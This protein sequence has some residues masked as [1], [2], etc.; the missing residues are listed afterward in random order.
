MKIFKILF[1]VLPLL[2]I[3]EASDYQAQ[4]SFEKLPD[5]KLKD[6]NKKKVSL[7][8]VCKD[9]YVVMNFWTMSCEPCKKEMKF[10]NEYHNKY[11]DSS[12]KVVS[13]NMDT[14]RGM[15][16]VKKY[17]KTS[18]Y[19]FDVLLDPRMEVF[20]KVGGNIMP[21][22]IVIDNKGNIT[23]KHIGYNKGDEKTLEEEIRQLIGIVSI[24]D[25][26]EDE[27]KI[28]AEPIKDVQE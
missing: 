10:L 1:L 9:S 15:S 7:I 23:N 4:K 19:A 25:N 14:P 16:K 22:V 18:K 27:I 11:Q 5:S 2:F 12:F 17:V 21:F 24:E 3:C 6:I 20:K 13:I 8:D 26:S 28:E